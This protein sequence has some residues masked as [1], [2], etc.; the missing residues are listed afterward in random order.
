MKISACYIAK[1]EENNIAHSLDSIKEYVD[2]LILVDTGSTDKTKKIF[3]SYGGKIYDLPWQEDFSTPRNVA[4]SKATGDWIILLDADELF[5]KE[6]AGNIS[7]L[8]KN[9]SNCDAFLV[10][11]DNVDK[12]ENTIKDSFYAIR[13][14]RNKGN[15]KY[16]GKIHEEITQNGHIIENMQRVSKN[17]LNIIHTGYSSDITAEK[18]KRNLNILLDEIAHGRDEAEC[19]TYLAECYQG[20]GNLKKAAEYATLDVSQGR[21]NVTYGSRSYRILIEYYR[22]YGTLQERL[23]SIEKAVSDFPELPEFHAEYSEYLL[24]CYEYEKA[25]Q[26]IE[27]AINLFENYD[28]LEPCLLPPSAI[29]IMKKRGDYLDKLITEM[30]KI[31]ISACVI[32]RNEEK[33]IGDWLHNASVFSDEII[34]VDTGSTDRTREICKNF[35]VECYK[36]EWED[37]F[38]AAK[39][40]AISKVTGE[41][42]VFTDTDELFYHP[43]RIRGYL[44]QLILSENNDIEAIMVPLSNVDVDANEMEIHR[45]NAIRIFR[46]AS[47]LKYFGKIHEALANMNTPGDSGSLKMVTADNRLLIRHTGY[48]SSIVKEKLQRNM[49]MLNKEIESVGLQEKHYRYLAESFYATGNY[50]ESLKFA[51]KAIEAKMQS[52][53]QKS[54]MLW[55]AANCL[56]ELE[57]SFTERKTFLEAAIREFSEIPDF[58]AMLGILL[59]NNEHYDA[60]IYYLEEA[61]TKADTGKATHFNS[62]IADVYTVLGQ[63]YWIEGDYEAAE[64]NIM[65]ALNINKWNDTALLAL[66]ELHGNE[67]TESLSEILRNLYG[68]NDNEYRLMQQT[69]ADNGIMSLAGDILKKEKKMISSGKYMDL[70]TMCLKQNAEHVQYLFVS[71]LGTN[72]D[73]TSYMNKQQLALLP[74]RLSDVVNLYHNGIQDDVDYSGIQSFYNYML[75]SVISIANVEIRQR[76]IELAELFG[77][78]SIKEAADKL[79]NAELWQEALSLYQQIPGEAANDDELFWLGAGTCFYQLGQCETAQEC[80]SKTI[81]ICKEKNDCSSKV[82]NEATSYLSW[83]QEVLA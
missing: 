29:D 6:T 25:R 20:L 40:Y 17:I 57:Y 78:S 14:V 1:N 18:S 37:D 27:Q 81:E 13:I 39:N 43:I 12:A 71:M 35:G 76:Y 52:I 45:F 4:L 30:K 55:L 3:A 44:A 74:G 70:Y 65:A 42:I 22:E 41:W 51:I 10:N 77:V 7:L 80:L 2:E 19:Y 59:K 56:D 31:K 79:R 58:Y 82:Y 50:D 21:K 75:P 67:L 62:I 26:E 69:F 60:A 34:V 68:N 38:A 48:S 23:N 33:N 11:I 54:D 24:Q 5:T 63:C 36:Y 66:A 72:I 83:C 16:K 47:Y 32:C 73:F 49:Y 53:G 9:Y 46:N 61:L 8:L 28:G 15:L 64:S